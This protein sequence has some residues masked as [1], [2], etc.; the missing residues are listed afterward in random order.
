MS[1]NEPKDRIEVLVRRLIWCGWGCAALSALFLWLSGPFSSA[2]DEG[3]VVVWAFYL[4]AARLAGIGAFAIGGVA[5]YNHRWTEGILL[6]LIAVL[7][8]ILSLY[9]HGTF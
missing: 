8:P 6:C 9:M 7:L 3:G 4:M 2:G 5:I 1:T